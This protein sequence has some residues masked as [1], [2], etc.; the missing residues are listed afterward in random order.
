[1]CATLA[2][3]VALLPAGV[4]LSNA[5]PDVRGAVRILLERYLRGLNEGD[6]DA[7]AECVAP[8][9]FNEHTA[10]LGASLHGRE[11]YRDRL[12]GFLAGF[13]DLHYEAEAMII[14]GDRAAVPYTF[15]GLWLGPKGE[16][17]EGR[18][19][20]IRG[21]FS[22]RVAGTEIAHRVDYWDSAEF[23]RQVESGEGN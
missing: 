22:F 15:S 14:D 5:E 17:Q 12:Q 9:F 1:M 21:I 10:T 13:I 4:V 7:V 6:A 11:A 23:L 3:T 2:C 18:P 16:Y 8:D 19:F 20:S